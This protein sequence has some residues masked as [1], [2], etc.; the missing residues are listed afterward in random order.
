M[1]NYWQNKAKFIGSIS[2][3]ATADQEP[4]GSLQLFTVTAAAR[5]IETYLPQ[6]HMNY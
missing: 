2:I 1:S 5:G 3:T 6:G 4:C